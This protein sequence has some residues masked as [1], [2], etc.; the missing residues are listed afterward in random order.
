MMR[1][2]SSKPVL[3]DLPKVSVLV[4][5]RNEEIDLPDCIDSLLNIDY[6][7]D[8]LE[9]ILVNDFS[10]DGTPE[11][12]KKAA[13]EN[14]HVK[15]YSSEEL[16]ETHLKAKARGIHN[17]ASQ[18]TGDWFFITDADC[19]VPSTWIRH[20]LDGVEDKHGIITACME[21]LNPSFV[22][23]MEKI[24]GFG[25]MVFAFGIAGYGLSFFA[26]GPNMAIRKEA[27]LKSGGLEKANFLIAEDIA[28]FKM[29]NSLGYQVKYHFDQYTLIH[30]TP[31]NTYQQLISQQVRWIKGGFEGDKMQ[32]IDKILIGLIL[33]FL[34]LV[35]L[36]IYAVITNPEY[37]L[38]FGSL[39]FFSDFIMMLAMK[40]KLKNKKFMRLLPVAF[41]YSI[42]IYAWL[43][44][45]AI[46]KRKVSWVG[47]GYEVKYN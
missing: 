27:Y 28:L 45:Y 19:R 30:L 40:L 35:F 9:I 16:P 43:P 47:D 5:C 7:K 36:M 24:V 17:A 15:Y 39:K 4:S 22:S 42:Y 37:L 11:L 13:S 38:I 26:L 41:V 29:A 2:K 12:L 32:A 46:L 14:D 20:M 25:K 6:P 34:P 44:T 23:T 33:V 10:T 21:T 8:L 31:V 3:E 18:A 1:F